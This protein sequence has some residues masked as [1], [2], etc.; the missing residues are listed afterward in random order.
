[1]IE[2]VC[3]RSHE[4]IYAQLLY[5]VSSKASRMGEKRNGTIAGSQFTAEVS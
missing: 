5:R 3:C 2:F 4:I 1:M